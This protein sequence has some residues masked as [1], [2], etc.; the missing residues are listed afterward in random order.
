MFGFPV[1]CVLNGLLQVL[2]STILVSAFDLAPWGHVSSEMRVISSSPR[3]TS[4]F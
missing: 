3:E 1:L 2:D 4:D